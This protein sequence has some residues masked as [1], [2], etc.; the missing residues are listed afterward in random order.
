M[1]KSLLAVILLSAVLTVRAQTPIAGSDLG[2]PSKVA[3]A[4]FGPNAFPV[5]LI[6]EG[7]TSLALSAELS[8]DLFSGLGKPWGEDLTVGPSFRLSLPLFTDRAT[9]NVWMPIVEWWQYGPET[10]AYRR[11]Q[12]DFLLGGKGHDSGDV[13]I[14]TDIHVLRA[15]G[16]RPDILIRACLKTASGNSFNEARYYDAAGYFFDATIANSL[17]FKGFVSE[18]RGAVSGGFLCWQTDNGRQN[19]AIQA[20]L[21]GMIDTRVFR[22]EAQCAGYFGWEKDGDMPVTVRAR[23]DFHARDFQPF[24]SAVYGIH[25]YPFWGISAGLRYRFDIA[26]FKRKKAEKSRND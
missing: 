6:P 15:K 13:Y 3:P 26:E 18:L 10:A 4:Y 1:R 7:R 24:V 11:L 5:P 16:W 23:L 12:G 22:F 14:S 2:I 21:M 19:D 20:G 25:D 8:A 17:Y 9:L